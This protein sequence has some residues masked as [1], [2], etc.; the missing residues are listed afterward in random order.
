M[1]FAIAALPFIFGEKWIP[2]T[3]L[4]F[5]KRPLPITKPAALPFFDD[6]FFG[7]MIQS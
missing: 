2:S 5:L 6:V 3:A 1:L 4:I 7:A